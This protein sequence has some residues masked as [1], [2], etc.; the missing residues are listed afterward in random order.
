MDT[1]TM[2]YDEFM[3]RL[4]DAYQTGVKEGQAKELA[5]LRGQKTYTTQWEEDIANIGVSGKGYWLFDRNGKIPNSRE[6]V[7]NH[8]ANAMWICPPGLFSRPVPQT[9]LRY[10][11]VVAIYK[12]IPADRS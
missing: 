3:A 10:L 5:K 2:P 7:F 11:A 8:R 9:I 1:I 6:G 12:W 4:N